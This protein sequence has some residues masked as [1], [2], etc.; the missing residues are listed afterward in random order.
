MES[1]SSSV[2]FI[3]QR[4]SPQRWWCSISHGFMPTSRKWSLLKRRASIQKMKPIRRSILTRRKFRRIIIQWVSKRTNTI[5][6][7]IKVLSTSSRSYLQLSSHICLESYEFRN[8]LEAC[9]IY[10]GNELKPDHNCIRKKCLREITGIWN[11]LRMVFSVNQSINLA[12]V[13]ER[14]IFTYLVRDIISES[15]EDNQ[16]QQTYAQIFQEFSVI[17]LLNEKFIRR[18]SEQREEYRTAVSDDCWPFRRSRRAV[19][20][21]C[22]CS[23]VGWKICSNSQA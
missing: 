21:P 20:A 14:W 16:C 15:I 2:L 9:E 1:P 11:E 3:N 13:F 6:H 7:M 12:H 18:G 17:I 5:S 10:Q 19:T 4:I 22:R 23:Q 8:C